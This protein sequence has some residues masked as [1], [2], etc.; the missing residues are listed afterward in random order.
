MA[1]ASAG[2]DEDVV[3]DPMTAVLAAVHKKFGKNSLVKASAMPRVSRI[4]TGFFSL[5]TAMGVTDGEAGLPE[6]RTTML[7]G[8]ESSAKSTILLAIIAAFQER[9]LPAVLVESEHTFDGEWADSWGVIEDDLLLQP[10]GSAQE[11]LDISAEV[12]RTLRRGVIGI[13]SMASL[14]P[15][16][17]IEASTSDWQQ[18]LSARLFN[19]GWRIFQSGQNTSATRGDEITH[20]CTIVVTQQWRSKIGPFPMKTIPGGAGQK[21][22]VSVLVSL[23]ED[24]QVWFD[25]KSKKI[26]TKLADETRKAGTG[27]VLGR[28]FRFEVKKNKS[29]VA[30]GMG[31]FRVYSRDFSFGSIRIQKG[32]TDHA[33][34]VLDRALQYGI[35]QQAGSWFSMGEERLGQG[36]ESV[37]SNLEGNPE[38]VARLQKLVLEELS[39]RRGSRPSPSPRPQTAGVPAEDVLGEDVVAGKKPG[40]KKAAPKKKAPPKKKGA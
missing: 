13:D 18:G 2:D 9:S 36:R 19:K 12:V 15:T 38:L 21:F 28:D 11:A 6:G 30:G 23:W 24:G 39:G 7:V 14:A 22:A 1:K 16:E 31:Q 20:G 40:P 5:D 25:P 35:V 10:A 33:A 26:V 37:A 29:D 17:E 8:D 4:S 32:T 27:V 34:Q 3:V